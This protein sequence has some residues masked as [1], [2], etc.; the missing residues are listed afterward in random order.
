MYGECFNGLKFKALIHTPFTEF[1]LPI[2]IPTIG[3]KAQFSESK[4]L[5]LWE[6]FSFRELGSNSKGESIV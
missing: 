2:V 6:K 4:A 5:Q 1:T 3:I